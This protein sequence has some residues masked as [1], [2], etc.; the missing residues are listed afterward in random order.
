MEDLEK[1]ENRSLNDL[2]TK[3]P[4]KEPSKDSLHG[5]EKA[6]TA[7]TLSSGAASSVDHGVTSVRD[8]VRLLK[9]T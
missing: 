3:V 4:S 2:S 7:E 8:E 5:L 1:G 9:A 6:E